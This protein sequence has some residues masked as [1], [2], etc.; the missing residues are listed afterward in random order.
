[1]GIR[2]L[3]FDTTIIMTVITILVVIVNSIQ[4]Q[5]NASHDLYA[6]QKQYIDATYD[7]YKNELI[8]DIL[9]GD[10]NISQ[11]LLDEI[12]Q[13]RKV[14][15][16]LTYEN[17]ILTSGKYIHQEPSLSYKL[18]LGNEKFALLKLYPLESL[19]SFDSLSRFIISLLLEIFVLG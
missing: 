7:I 17:T 11:Y 13:S 14:G 9:V 8:G 1:M 5:L 16:I 3:F 4:V 15:V 18:N 19:K 12:S 2:K 6:L 10:N